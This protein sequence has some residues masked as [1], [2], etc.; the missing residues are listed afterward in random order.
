MPPATQSLPRTILRV[1]V[2]WALAALVLAVVVQFARL[3]VLVLW[4]K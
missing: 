3:F 4:A 1:G 2:K